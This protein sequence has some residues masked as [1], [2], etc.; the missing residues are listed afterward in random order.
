MRRSAGSPDSARDVGAARPAVTTGGPAG[1]APSE[2]TT[3]DAVL[4][5][6]PLAPFPWL[7]LAAAT[8]VLTVVQ[9]ATPTLVGIDGYF[10]VRYAQVIREAGLR[11]FPP[12]F[13]WLPLTILAPD[14]YA[15]HHML[16]HLL[17]VPFTFGDLR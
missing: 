9:F 14:R 13:P 11:G 15:D 4:G 6:G 5:D 10:H 1:A 16:Y 17:L 8:I 12:R 7:A 2:A 3:S